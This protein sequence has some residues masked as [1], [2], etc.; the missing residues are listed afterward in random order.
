M[1]RQRLGQHYL[2]DTGAL[3]KLVAAAGLKGNEVVLE[4]GT[5][6]GVLTRELSKLCARLEAFEIDQVN[7]EK[8]RALVTSANVTLHLADAF[9]SNPL[10]DVLVS[11]LPYSRSADFVEWL[12]QLRYDRAVVLLQEDFVK[13][14]SSPPGT[15]DYRAISVISQLSARIKIGDLVGSWSFTPQ[16]KINS[17]I[18]TFTPRVRLTEGQIHFIKRL[19]ALRRR[20]LNSALGELEIKLPSGFRDPHL[21]VHQLSPSE[22]FSLVTFAEGGR[23]TEATRQGAAPT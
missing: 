8:T 7:F 9:E 10:F 23:A 21:R 17:R 2:T 18:V 5:G 13:K 19:F 22:V 4:I 11:S 14:I 15:R 1:K 20:T 16:P 12:G 6:R 3:R